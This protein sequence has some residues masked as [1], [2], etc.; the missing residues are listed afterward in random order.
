MEK[1]D[2]L[3]YDPFVEILP[4][5]I[6]SDK[7]HCPKCHVPVTDIGTCP[8]CHTVITPKWK[9][10]PA[11]ER[12]EIVKKKGFNRKETVGF[13]KVDNSYFN[14]FTLINFNFDVQFKEVGVKYQTY[15]RLN[16]ELNESEKAMS[17]KKGKALYLIKKAEP[18]ECGC[19]SDVI[20]LHHGQI[21]CPTCGCVHDVLFIVDGKET[22]V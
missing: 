14:Q 16:V 18:C 8:Y 10:A 21:L 4:S 3:F 7:P 5:R 20:D 13:K 17:N 6:K 12:Y 15:P 1:P 9:P 11:K 19:T 22:R 2:D